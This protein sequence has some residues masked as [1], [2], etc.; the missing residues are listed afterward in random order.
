[1][2]I[3]RRACTLSPGNT[4]AFWQARQMRGLRGRGVAPAD[5]THRV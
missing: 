3:E 2:L 4:A 5:R 1:M